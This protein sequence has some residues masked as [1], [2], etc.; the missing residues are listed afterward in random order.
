MQRRIDMKLTVLGTSGPFPKPGS[1]C[2]GYLLESDNAKILL[3]CGSGVVSRL[4][5]ICDLSE[6]DAVVLTHL[7]FD[8][9]SDIGVLRYALEASPANRSVRLLAPDPDGSA[10]ERF[11]SGT[12]VLRQE[13]VSDGAEFVIGGL[14]LRFSRAVHPVEAYCVRIDGPDRSFFYTGDTAVFDG[15]EDLMRGADLAVSDSC[16]TDAQAEVRKE[17]HM[18][19]GQIGLLRSRAGVKKMVLSHHFGGDT[20]ESGSESVP[21]GCVYAKDL[22]VFEF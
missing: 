17:I 21:G 8:H 9:C 20:A 1:A 16:F 13:T 4:L 15:L 5:Q 11:L 2:S 14:R 7:H 12:G 18:S 6:L 3:D 10:L 22:S 19:P